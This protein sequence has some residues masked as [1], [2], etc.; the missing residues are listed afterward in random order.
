MI[1]PSTHIDHGRASFD[2]RVKYIALG[3]PEHVM[4]QS[5]IAGHARSPGTNFNLGDPEASRRLHSLFL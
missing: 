4:K 2:A 5:G 3:T 1:I